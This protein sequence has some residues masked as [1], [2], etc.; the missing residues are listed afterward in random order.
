MGYRIREEKNWGFRLS[1]PVIFNRERGRRDAIGIAKSVMYLANVHGCE[2]LAT[3]L[4]SA[5][6]SV[7]AT[8]RAITTGENVPDFVQM[9]RTFVVFS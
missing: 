9:S 4:D 2:L 7:S 3:P 5:P 8:N 1:D 6:G